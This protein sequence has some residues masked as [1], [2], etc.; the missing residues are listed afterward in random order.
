LHALVASDLVRWSWW[1]AGYVWRRGGVV[2]AGRALHKLVANS[3]S[4]SLSS[5]GWLL[6]IIII[7][8]LI[9]GFQRLL[10]AA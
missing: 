3:S 6:L 10:F 7:G 8:G 5:T 9:G 2:A 1:L 4:R